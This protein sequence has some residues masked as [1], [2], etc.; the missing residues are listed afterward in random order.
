M[1]QK[2]LL[3]LP[4]NKD[5][6]LLAHCASGDTLGAETVL[7]YPAKLMSNCHVMESLKGEA[8]YY[9]WNPSSRLERIESMKLEGVVKTL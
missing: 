4:G 8:K 1:I 2:A 7:F 9:Y 3:S 6:I 5:H